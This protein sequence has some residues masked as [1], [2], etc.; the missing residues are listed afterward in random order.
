VQKQNPKNLTPFFK[1]EK[2]V[3]L[4]YLFG[5]HAK[6]TQTPQSDIDIAVLLSETPKKLLEYHLYLTNKLSKITGN[7]I[8]LII[9]NTAPPLLKHQIIKHGKILYS[10]NKETRIKFEAKAQTE[11]LD[12]SRAIERYN[13]CFMKQTLT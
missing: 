1:N 10:Q 6:N 12:F 2:K 8:D 9:L 13:E 7:E 4:A 3:T 5:S 11:Y